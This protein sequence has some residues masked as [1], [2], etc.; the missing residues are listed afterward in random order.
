MTRID[1][2]NNF[3]RTEFF[4]ILKRTLNIKSWGK[5][6]NF[7]DCPRTSFQ[8]YH[9]GK[10]LI[11]ENLFQKMIRCLNPK[12][13]SYFEKNI[14]TKNDNWGVVKGGQA[15]YKKYPKL[16]EIAREKAI[17]KARQ[18]AFE[19]PVFDISLSTEL[20]EFVGAM[21]GDGNVDGYLQ[22]KNKLPKYH[23]SITGNSVDDF[24]YLSKY[25]PKIIQNLFNVKSKVIFRKDCNAMVLNVYSKKVFFLFK[26]RFGF[27]PGNKTYSIKIPFEIISSKDKFVFATIRGIFDTDGTVFFDKRKIYKKP[28][29][30]IALQIV[31]KD[32]FLQLKEFLGKY[33][34][35]YSFINKKRNCYHLEIYGEKQLEKWILLVGF[36]NQKHLNKIEKYVKLQPGSAPGTPSLPMTCNETGYA[37]GALC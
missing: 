30:R 18:K 27:T 37:T 11:P 7:F 29:P 12:D 33:F 6:Q 13:K 21:I 36:S 35:L 8:A 25:F 14:I 17:K 34:L 15:T 32:L 22:K 24:D 28:Y 5:L 1:F 3:V 10:Y 2:K 31:S 19:K 23:L 4:K 26:E 16:A 20:C 9:Y